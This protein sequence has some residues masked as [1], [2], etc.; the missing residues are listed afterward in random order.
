MRRW[1]AILAVT[2]MLAPGR[3][4]G[5]AASRD[6]ILAVTQSAFDW[7]LGQL[8]TEHLGS[9]DTNKGWIRAPFFVGALAM[10]GQTHNDHYLSPILAIARQNEFQPGKRFRH[11]DD[12]AI[13]QVYADLHF[14]THDAA[15]IRPMRDRWDAIMQQP[16]A[17]RVDW[18]WC[19]A[20]FMAPP[21]I[22]RLGA[23]TGD[24][25]YFDFADRQWWDTTDFLYDKT[26]RLYFRDKSYF[27]TR[28]KNGQKIFWSRGNGWVMAGTARVLQYLPKD[29]PSRPR[30]M[31]LF[32]D[33]AAR[34]AP[35]QQPDG[36]WRTSL[37]DPASCPG[38]ESSGTGF[39]CYAMA[40][41]IEQGLL[42]RDEYL[43]VVQ[44]AWAAISGAVEPSGKLDWVQ[45]PGAKPALIQRGDSEEYGVGALLLAGSEMLRLNGETK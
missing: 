14:I 29:Y 4:F 38:G 5:Q 18:W 36:F 9:D 7:Q 16:M 45:K 6:Q 27:N 17:G 35:L 42:P 43:P 31:K 15:M 21:A 2:M 33:M 23:A 28:E 11:A 39:F 37:L 19:D 25:K 30:Y 34:I 1:P 44:R 22:V 40:W 41:G 8:P 26:E 12:Q 32:T 13:G 20:L 24:A 10:Y 3:A